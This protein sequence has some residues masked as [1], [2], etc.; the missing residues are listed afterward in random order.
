MFMTVPTAALHPFAETVEL[1]PH[2]PTLRFG[3]VSLPMFYATVDKS[4]GFTPKLEDRPLSP[5]YGCL[6]I[7]FVNTLTRTQRE[8][9]CG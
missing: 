4:C 5:V 7:A 1:S 8:V 2:H 6:F 3:D 9:C